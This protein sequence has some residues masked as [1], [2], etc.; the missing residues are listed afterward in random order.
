MRQSLGVTSR[1]E[2]HEQPDLGEPAK[3]FGEGS[4]RGAVREPGV[5][6]DQAGEVGGEESAGV[7]GAGGGEA[8]DAQPEC[9][10]R[11]QAGGG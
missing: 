4:G 10:Q 9:G 11:V 6:Q 7:R 8:D 5:G 2:Q 1:P 3:A